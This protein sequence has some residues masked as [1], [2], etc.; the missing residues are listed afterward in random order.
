MAA[1]AHDA[2]A[3]EHGRPRFTALRGARGT[4]AA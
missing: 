1:I 2:P 4:R 3:A